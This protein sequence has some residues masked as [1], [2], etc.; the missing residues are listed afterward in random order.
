M[1]AIHRADKR[2]LLPG[3]AASVFS[4][5]GHYTGAGMVM[6][7]G[8]RIIRPIILIVLALLFIKII[9]GI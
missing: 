4:I 1:D 8:S 3:I 7:N 2:W 9:S 6:K 5:A